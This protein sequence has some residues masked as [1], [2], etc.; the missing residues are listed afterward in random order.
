MPPSVGTR[1]RLSVGEREVPLE[2]EEDKELS[3][4]A[5]EGRWS[6]LKIMRKNFRNRGMRAKS[7]AAPAMN[8]K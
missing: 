7:T 6:W 3:E 2:E 1:E 4:G 8:Q 5:R